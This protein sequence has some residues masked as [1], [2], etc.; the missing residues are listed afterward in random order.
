MFRGGKNLGPQAKQLR[1]MLAART[2]ARPVG[3]GA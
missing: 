3:Y 1:Y 2:G